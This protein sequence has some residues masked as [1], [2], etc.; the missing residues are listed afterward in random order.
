[1][2]LS[3]HRVLIAVV[4]DQPGFY[5]TL[6]A[7]RRSIQRTGQAHSACPVSPRRA[8]SMSR[9]TQL[10]NPVSMARRNARLVDGH[11]VVRNGFNCCFPDRDRV[12][13]D[14]FKEQLGLFGPFD[15]QGSL[16]AFVVHEHHGV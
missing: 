10:I 3:G 7:L 2:L 6:A 11:A 8:R 5:T 14:L 12:L 13:L 16:L 15:E 1:M 9:S 4:L